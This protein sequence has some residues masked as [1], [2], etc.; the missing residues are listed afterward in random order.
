MQGGFGR[1]AAGSCAPCGSFRIHHSA[2][3][4]TLQAQGQAYEQ[5]VEHGSRRSGVVAFV[6]QLFNKQPLALDK[7]VNLR[8]APLCL[9]QFKHAIKLS[10][11]ETILNKAAERN[12]VRSTASHLEIG[13]Q[14]TAAQREDAIGLI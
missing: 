6:S 10:F 1:R 8:D 5:T 14:G 2:K 7:P 12:G 11:S 13:Q 4:A 9:Q 3:A